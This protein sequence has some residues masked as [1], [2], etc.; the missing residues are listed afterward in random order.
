MP[1]SVPIYK[2]KFGDRP[3]AADAINPARLQLE[4]HSF[5][6][7]VA[8]PFDYSMNDAGTIAPAPKGDGYVYSPDGRRG[9]LVPRVVIEQRAIVAGGD[10]AGG[11]V[12]AYDVGDPP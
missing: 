7:A 11:V 3:S 9:V 8:I 12:Q 6:L 1:V 10:D 2:Y 5:L 4:L